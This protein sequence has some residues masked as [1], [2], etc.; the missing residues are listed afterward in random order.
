VWLLLL[1]APFFCLLPD[2]TIKIFSTWWSRTP[3]DWQLK[4]IADSKNIEGVKAKDRQLK[5]KKEKALAMQRRQ[6]LRKLQPLDY[7]EEDLDD[8]ETVIKKLEAL[9]PKEEDE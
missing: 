7:G 2:I 8:D 9:R 3:I 5:D 6:E 1:A 4:E